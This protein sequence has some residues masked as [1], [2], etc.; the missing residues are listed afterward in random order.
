MERKA[1]FF[2]MAMGL[3]TKDRGTDAAAVEVI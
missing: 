1:I 2:L 3:S